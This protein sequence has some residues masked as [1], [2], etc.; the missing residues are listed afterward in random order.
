MARAAFASIGGLKSSKAEP[1]ASKPDGTV[2]LL[3]RPN[4]MDVPPDELR[5]EA[6]PAKPYVT[7]GNLFCSWTRVS[8]V[9]LLCDL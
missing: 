8:H 2:T 6:P 5:M 1:S 7:H 9:L 4:N 3:G